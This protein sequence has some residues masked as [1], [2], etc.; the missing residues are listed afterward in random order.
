MLVA[1][2][3]PP[4]GLAAGARIAA[5]LVG[6]ARS[7]FLVPRDAIVYEEGGAFVYHELAQKPGDDKTYYARKPV[8]LLMR[9]GDGWLVDGLDDDDRIVVRGN[10]VLWSLEGIGSM[11]ADDD[12]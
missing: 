3:H 7:G 12:D 1:I 6:S 9:S 10:G 11:P 2:D 5:T 4:A 8:T